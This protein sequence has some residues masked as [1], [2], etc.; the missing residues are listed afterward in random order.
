MMNN[1]L[2]SLR[3]A[4]AVVSAIAAFGVTDRAGDDLTS[5]CH[6]A[7]I[8]ARAGRA[9]VCDAGNQRLVKLAL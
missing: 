9:V 5:L 6:P 7:M 8:A 1:K 3:T 2:C 4:Q